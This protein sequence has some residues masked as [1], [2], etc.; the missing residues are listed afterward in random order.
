MKELTILRHLVFF[1]SIL[2]SIS[3]FGDFSN[4]YPFSTKKWHDLGSLKS[5]FFKKVS[6]KILQKFAERRQIDLRRGMP[7]F[8]L[9][10]VAP[11]TLF[12]KN[13]RGVGSDPP[14]PG[15][16]RVNEPATNDSYTVHSPVAD[17]SDFIPTWSAMATCQ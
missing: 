7:S 6:E 12:K 14:P 8:A 3:I 10:P 1:V 17:Q 13:R 16:S 11:R 2:L 15:R 9:I 5:A 4:I